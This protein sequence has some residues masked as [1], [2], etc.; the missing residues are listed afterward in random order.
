MIEKHKTQ[1]VAEDILRIFQKQDLKPEE[2]LTVIAL[3][4]RQ[5]GITLNAKPVPLMKMLHAALTRLTDKSKDAEIQDLI[6]KLQ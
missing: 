4:F 6:Y 1:V 2:A 3:V 5:V